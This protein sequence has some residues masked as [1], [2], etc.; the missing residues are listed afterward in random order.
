MEIFPQDAKPSPKIFSY[1]HNTESAQE[2]NHPL[3]NKL[4]CFPVAI[5][6]LLIFLVKGANAQNPQITDSLRKALDA[7]PEM[8]SVRLS[9]MIPLANSLLST[10]PVGAVSLARSSAFLA[11]SLG[12]V[13]QTAIAYNQ[14]GNIFHAQHDNG[15]AMEYYIQAL[16]LFEELGD[17]KWESNLHANIGNI[18]LSQ[19]Q[20]EE[21]AREE[22]I[23]L[24]IREEIGDY[25]R[26]EGIFNTFGNILARQKEYDRAL[27]YFEMALDS[28]QKKGNRHWEAMFLGNIG[29]VYG[30]TGNFE[31]SRQKNMA[32]YRIH[33][34][35]G[36]L[37]DQSRDLHNIGFVFHQQKRYD[38]AAV[39]YERSYHMADSLGLKEVMFVSARGLLEVYNHSGKHKKAADWGLV[40]VKVQD[41]LNAQLNTRQI[42]NA[43]NRYKIDKEEMQIKFTRDK[44]D[45]AHREALK[46]N[47]ILSGSAGTGFVLISL[48][49]AVLFMRYREKQAYNQ[50]L[51]G[52]V[53]ERTIQLVKANERLMNE[54]NAKELA[55]K[56]LN[57]FI[58]RSSHDLKGPLASMQGLLNI[59]QKEEDP[60]H[61]LGL[62]SDKVN[63]LDGVLR[64]LIDKVEIENRELKTETVNWKEVMRETEGELVGLKGKGKVKLEIED[65]TVG[66]I[67]A[68]PFAVGL[69]LRQL[70]QNAIQ[71]R[72]EKKEACLCMVSIEGTRQNW[73]LVVEDNGKG[74]PDESQSKVFEMFF[75]SNNMA[76]G[77]GLGL[78][79][80]KETVDRMNGKIDLFS[81]AGV[82]TRIT[83]SFT[84]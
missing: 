34:E 24:K 53:E 44:Q 72:D 10:D 47:R 29:N 49:A 73:S 51:E 12:D 61:Y 46:R 42:Q 60:G 77:S 41:S 76:Q 81:K 84:G 30:W 78:Y 80:V 83:L 75:S 35:L 1:I 8:D 18:H 40:T 14:L 79:I 2:P 66:D 25:D 65:K 23:A 67:S 58:Y 6:F 64:Q 70:V 57:T 17:R 13:R 32:A 11:D 63:Q 74:I 62:V 55:Q 3:M 68:D 16:E 21:A 56:D 48:F 33:Q 45:M 36:M 50:R 22:E 15:K 82:G 37:V 7:H 27:E 38:S 71:F 31:L 69:I 28:A 52:T 4:N 43:E 39:Y 26:I 59:A 19:K 20:F 9:I 5:F 54:V